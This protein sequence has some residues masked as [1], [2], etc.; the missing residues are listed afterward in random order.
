MTSCH[1]SARLHATDRRS[2][3]S[4]ARPRFGA[5]KLAIAT[6]L[7]ILSFSQPVLAASKIKIGPLKLGSFS[8]LLDT[9]QHHGFDKGEGIDIARGPVASAE[10]TRGGVLSHSRDLIVTVR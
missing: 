7:A 8:W 5:V 3:R 9:I 2:F 4:Q 6:L 10:A 1:S